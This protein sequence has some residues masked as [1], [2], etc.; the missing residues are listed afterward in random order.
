MRGVAPLLVALASGWTAGET[1][2]P[3]Q[4]AGLL[5]ISSGVLTLAFASGGPGNSRATAIA[6]ATAAVIATY[7]LVDGIGVRLSGSPAAYTM[8]ILMLP[9]VPLVALMVRTPARARSFVAFARRRALHGLIGGAGSLVS[10]GLVL[11]AMTQAPVAVVA[12]LRET[13][14]LFAAAISALVLKERVTTSRVVAAAVIA[15]GAAVLRLA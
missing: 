11:W 7:T 3:G 13:S 15:S 1:L 8:W 14:I 5:L 6:L 2:G 4:W 9:S 12:A 10:Y